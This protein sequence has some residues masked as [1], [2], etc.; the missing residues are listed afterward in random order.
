M[1]L[2]FIGG[3]RILG[4]FRVWGLGGLGLGVYEKVVSGFRRS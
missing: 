1:G 4:F 2:G 3:V